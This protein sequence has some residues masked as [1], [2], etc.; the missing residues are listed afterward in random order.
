MIRRLTLA[1]TAAVAFSSAAF[2]ADVV[3][4]WKRDDGKTKVR[5]APCGG[6]AVCGS[7][8]WLR[9]A[10]SPAKVGQQVFFDMKPNG[11][12]TW[13]GT[14]FN[15]DDGAHL[16]R[17]DDAGGRSSD[18]RRLRLRRAH[19][20]DGR[21]D[22]RAVTRAV[23][24]GLGL[25]ALAASPATGARLPT[26]VE[27]EREGDLRRS[28]R[29]RRRRRSRQGL[30]RAARLARPEG[31]GAT[32]RRRGRLAGA[33]RLELRR[34]EGPGARRLPGARDP[35]AHRLSRRRARRGPRRAGPARAGLPHAERRQGPHR[36]RRATAEVRRRR[37]AGRARV[38]RR[39]R[40][41]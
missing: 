24:V 1:A 38:Q 17:Q 2:A 23:L 27:R 37:D 19:L 5:F 41:T 9:D 8:T 18:D 33:A 31:Q 4:E 13:A 16:H 32:R 26:R 34:R 40:P 12:G 36:R 15:P 39:G 28:D 25:A 35:R 7:I 6:G 21:V 22:A 14:A 29:A 30:R 11:E 3:G 20:Q 10:D